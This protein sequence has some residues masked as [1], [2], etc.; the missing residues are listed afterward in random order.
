MSHEIHTPGNS[1]LTVDYRWKAGG[2]WSAIKVEA[3][4]EPE[5]ARDGSHEQFI[6]GHYWGYAAQP[7]GGCVE[8]RV[9]HP[10]WRVWT[11]HRAEFEGDAEWLYG[12][13]MAAVLRDAPGSA[14]LAEGSAVTVMRGRRI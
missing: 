6:T 5:L 4:G 13:D 8:Y 12:R 1:R 7:D 2:A 14:F 11:A 9:T 3:Q 10:S